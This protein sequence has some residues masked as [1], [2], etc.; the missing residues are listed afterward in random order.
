M[1]QKEN[2][3]AFCPI[4]DI[5]LN[6]F[7]NMILNKICFEIIDVTSKNDEA[8]TTITEDYAK[9]ILEKHRNNLLQP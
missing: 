3:R 6:L 9:E 2:N 8:L 7:K 4:Q 5:I 1:K